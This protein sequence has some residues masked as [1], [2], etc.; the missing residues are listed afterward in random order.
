MV[1]FKTL[2]QNIE[3]LHIKTAMWRPHYLKFRTQI[4]LYVRDPKGVILCYDI[5]DKK[6]FT[7]LEQSINGFKSHQIDSR[8]DSNPKF[9]LVGLKLDLAKCRC[10]TYKEAHN[11]ATEHGM[12]YY[13]V[14]SLTGENVKL[15][16]NTFITEI[17]K[18]MYYTILGDPVQLPDETFI[19]KVTIL[20]KSEAKFPSYLTLQ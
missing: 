20:P 13:E 5:T 2:T 19:S 9:A 8:T 11:W 17:V 1:D 12:A 4:H 6:S 10:V 18:S 15:F 7:Y 16:F 14:S 3:G